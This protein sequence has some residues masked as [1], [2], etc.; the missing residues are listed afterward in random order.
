MTNYEKIKKMN[1]EEMGKFI[2]S[3]RICGYCSQERLRDCDDQCVNN[4]IE[5]LNQESD[6]ED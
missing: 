6:K 2:D 1:I 4:R 5:W 3:L